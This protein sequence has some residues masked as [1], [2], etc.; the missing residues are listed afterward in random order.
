MLECDTAGL[1]G[2]ADPRADGESSHRFVFEACSIEFLEVDV[3]DD[4]DAGCGLPG[5]SEMDVGDHTEG[6]VDLLIPLQGVRG[7]EDNLAGSGEPVE[8]AGEFGEVLLIEA[9]F[10]QGGEGVDE[11]DVRFEEFAAGEESFE[12]S[13]SGKCLGKGDFRGD[14][15]EFTGHKVFADVV[16]DG[17]GLSQEAFNG[18]LGGDVGAGAVCF[19][20]AEAEALAEDAFPCAFFSFDEDEGAGR[21]DFAE[22]VRESIVFSLSFKED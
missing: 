10:Q 11:D 22:A 4:A 6:V 21:D 13:S 7:A 14:E 18:E 20:E 5:C 9:F 17:C 16:A 15:E 19:E 2:Q 1:D 12:K 8:E 3:V